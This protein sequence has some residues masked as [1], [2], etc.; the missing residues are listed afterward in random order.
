MPLRSSDH[1]CLLN[2]VAIAGDSGSRVNLLRRQAGT[3]RSVSGGSPGAS[4]CLVATAI[5]CHVQPSR[6]KVSST[7][8]AFGNSWEG[9][10]V[11]SSGPSRSRLYS[12]TTAHPNR[13]PSSDAISA[14]HSKVPPVG[15]WE[16][17]ELACARASI[18]VRARP[19]TFGLVK[20]PVRQH[21]ATSLL[22]YVKAQGPRRSEYL[23]P[24]GF[25]RNGWD[26][27]CTVS[28]VSP[29]SVRRT[30]IIPERQRHQRLRMRSRGLD[31]EPVVVNMQPH[32]TE[33]RMIALHQST[34]SHA[35][36]P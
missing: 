33:V 21:S 29:Q 25:R 5:T 24:L 22:A 27:L 2:L 11:V 20:T 16:V 18:V 17:R 19:R 32:L 6:S 26:E 12:G 10:Y 4:N 31:D 15:R 23:K 30:A 7:R 28:I 1:E 8:T 35:C 13:R 9:T 36:E 14:V 3:Q 34:P